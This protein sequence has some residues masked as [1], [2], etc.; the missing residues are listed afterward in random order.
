MEMTAGIK[1]IAASSRSLNRG[2]ND[3]EEEDDDYSDDDDDGEDDK[4]SSVDENPPKIEFHEK[5]WWMKGVHPRGR[6]HEAV[7]TR[8]NLQKSPVASFGR[9]AAGVNAANAGSASSASKQPEAFTGPLFVSN[10]G[11]DF[12]HNV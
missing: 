3:D 5:P 4:A 10:P 12:Q 11:F 9:A 1:S 2:G 6:D 7:D 8:P